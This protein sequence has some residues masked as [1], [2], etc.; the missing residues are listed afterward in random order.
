ME[1]DDL[2]NKWQK[3]NSTITSTS[4]NKIME[5]SQQKSYGPV[6]SLR[7]ALGKQ[8]VII[9]FLL[10]VLIIQ[11][12]STPNLR[13]DP[14]FGLLAGIIVLGSVFF[15]VAYFILKKMSKSDVPVADQLRRQLRS[16]RQMLLCYR[17]ISLAGVVMLVIFLEVFKN[18]GTAQLMQPWYEI[19]LEFRICAYIGLMVLSF[20]LSRSRFYKDFG[21]HLD[22]LK[23]SLSDTE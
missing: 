15:T 5:L 20:F 17:L 2:K 8:V 12:A 11:V 7:A 16:L 19:S 9:P 22:E 14:F 21:K 6:A 23:K 3:S 18:M 13:T 10:I 1:I 4:K